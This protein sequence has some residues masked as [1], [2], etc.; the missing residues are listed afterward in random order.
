MRKLCR[1]S[2]ECT[3]MN[4][5][6]TLRPSRMCSPCHRRIMTYSC[7]ARYLSRGTHPAF[8]LSLSPLCGDLIPLTHESKVMQWRR[9]VP[10]RPPREVLAEFFFAFSATAPKKI[11]GIFFFLLFFDDFLIKPISKDKNRLALIF[12]PLFMNLL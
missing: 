2:R 9:C 11:R 5:E 1:E 3:D 8:S 6:R 4:D 12:F 7:A 10:P